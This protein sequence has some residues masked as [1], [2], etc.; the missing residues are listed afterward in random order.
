VSSACVTV[1]AS[2]LLDSPLC[3]DVFFLCVSAQQRPSVSVLSLL[4]ALVCVVGLFVV[5]QVDRFIAHYCCRLTIVLEDTS[6]FYSGI[7][8]VKYYSPI[9]A[10]K[11]FLF[12]IVMIVPKAF[13]LCVGF[14]S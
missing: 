11:P 4:Y 7:F 2:S 6:H 3:I 9:L 1:S 14:V 8:F 5:A 10:T 12:T 13:L